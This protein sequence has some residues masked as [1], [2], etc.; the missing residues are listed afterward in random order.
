[1][2]VS[3]MP[4]QTRAR[5]IGRTALE[6]SSVRGAMGIVHS[7][8]PSAVNILTRDNHLISVVSSR[9]G[10]GPINLVADLPDRAPM[11]SMGLEEGDDVWSEGAALV[12]PDRVVISTEGASVYQPERSFGH[13]LLPASGIENNLTAMLRYAR[14]RG[15]SAVAEYVMRQLPDTPPGRSEQ[16]GRPAP[17]SFGGGLS[18]EMQVD[19]FAGAALPRVSDFLLA[20]QERSYPRIRMSASNLIGLGPGLTPSC[21]DILA[22]FMASLRFAEENRIIAGDHIT[23]VIEEI[24]S[25][26]PNRTTILSEEYLM[27][28]AVGEANEPVVSLLQRIL[29]AGPGEVRSATRRLLSVGASSGTEIALGILLGLRIALGRRIALGVAA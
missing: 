1:L 12:V 17:S 25:C 4:L 26:V 19:S 27:H 28:A 13:A 5:S 9:V 14:V 24:A 7:I 23:R 16:S 3:G 8:F 21:D 29:T 11:S 15:R 20:V 10:R 2:G 22:G 18:T 6:R